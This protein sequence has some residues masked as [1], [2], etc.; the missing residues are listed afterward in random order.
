MKR[1]SLN[2][3][4]VAAL[5]TLSLTSC[6]KFLDINKD[7]D[8]IPA[9]NPPLAQLLTS[10]QVNL[11]FEGG[12]DLYRYTALVAQH[13]SGQASQPNQTYEYGRYNISGSDANNVWSSIFAT[14]L[15]D[16]ELIIKNSSTTSPYYSGIARILKSYEYSLVVDTWGDVPY[17]EALKF[18][19]NT[20][21][22][23]DAGDAVYKALIANLDLAI[24]DLGATTSVLTPG[25]N[26]IIYPGTFA[27]TKTNWIKLANTLKL[28]LF[29]HYS[30]KDPAYML[31]QITTLVNSTAPLFASNADNFQLAFI[32]APNNTNPIHQFEINRANY[33]FA[34]NS[35]VTLMNSK[36]DP[37]RP[38][39]FTSFP[40]TTT[41]PFSY[42]GVTPG[43]APSVNFS[44]LHTY[45]RGAASGTATP[46]AQGGI[47]A[48][49]LT[50][51]G[52]AP[53]RMLT[54]AEYCFIRAEAAL[55][56]APGVAQTWYQA[57]ITAS[58]TDAGVAAVDIATYI[59]ARGT[60]DGTPAQQLQ[61][62]IEEKYVALF[63]V[64]VEPW[65][66]YRRTGYPVLIAPSNASV[67]GTGV[68]RSLFYPQ[69]EIDLNPNAKQKANMDVK[70]FW[71][72]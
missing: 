55:R 40:Y 5:A 63:G 11:A 54:Y 71:D 6:K 68:P 3:L 20:Q 61:K 38:F 10:A 28:R 69:S 23:Y 44:R 8:N 72:N 9:D 52:A 26:S 31:A 18:D 32:A 4:T 46:N 65:T 13:L 21:P 19:G 51:T 62:V 42:K 47:T 59:T 17:T 48:T 2:V 30:K 12:S 66:D 7:P 70:V 41:A 45:L 57:G 43:D 50:Y 22:K 29:L 60:L 33:L 24:A 25:T 1:I 36:A 58:M 64:S 16:L 39:Y 35:F 34:D 37:R 27:T 53:I 67:P 14:T 56:G 49:A 15:S